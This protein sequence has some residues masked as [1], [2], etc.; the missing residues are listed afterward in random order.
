MCCV[1]PPASVSTTADSRIAS[2]SVVF[3]W[4]TWPMI[5][6]TGGLAWSDSSG[7]SKASG[8]SSSSSAC[9]MVTSRLTLGSAAISPTASSERDFVMVTISPS[10]IMILMICATG[11]P[12]ACESSLTVTPD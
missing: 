5:V 12:S 4:S 2:S 1:I 3:P 10:P 9:L 8:S 6:T 11:I 7:S